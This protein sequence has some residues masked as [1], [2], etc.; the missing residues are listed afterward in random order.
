MKEGVYKLTVKWYEN[1]G[2]ALINLYWTYPGRT[3]T[4]LMS[5]IYA[6]EGAKLMDYAN[7]PTRTIWKVESSFA[8]FL[9]VVDKSNVPVESTEVLLYNVTGNANTLLYTTTTDTNGLA[10]LSVSVYG[11]YMVVVKNE[12]AYPTWSSA[13]IWVSVNFTF[14][15]NE[16][17][18]HSRITKTVTLPL[19]TIDLLVTDLNGYPMCTTSDEITE[20]LLYNSSLA[21]LTGSYIPTNA[22]GYVRFYRIPSGNYTVG[23][24]YTTYIY[25]RVY[26]ED[27]M[28]N[29]SFSALTSGVRV[30]KT[31][32]TDLNVR[33][34]SVDNRSIPSATV[35][36]RRIISGNL[37]I[38]YNITTSDGI[39]TFYRVLNG[40]WTISASYTNAW[41]QSISNNSNSFNIQSDAPNTIK[42][43][44]TDL[45]VYVIDQNTLAPLPNSNV[46]IFEISAPTLTMSL[47]TNSSGYSS[48][49][50][51]LAGSYNISTNYQ[52]NKQTTTADVLSSTVVTVPIVVQYLNNH[53][54]L[55][56][57]SDAFHSVYW[58][59]NITLLVN[60]SYYYN[61]MSPITNPD[62]LNFTVYLGSSVIYTAST[63]DASPMFIIDH[64]NGNYTLMINTTALSMYPASTYYSIVVEAKYS[65][66]TTDPYPSPLLFTINVVPADTRLDVTPST[67]TTNW[68]DT[69]TLTLNYTDAIHSNLPITDANV[70]YFIYDYSHNLLVSNNIT[71]N[72]NIYSVVIPTE[73]YNLVPGDYI[74]EVYIGRKG[75]VNRT[76]SRTLTVVEAPTSLSLVTTVPITVTW[77]ENVSLS[78]KHIN[79]VNLAILNNS[80]VSLSINNTYIYPLTYNATSG[81]YE[82][83]FNSSKLLS[84]TYHV[85]VFTYKQYFLP[86]SVEFTL[87]VNPVPIHF[88]AI[89]VSSA[90]NVTW[91]DVIVLSFYIKTN[92]TDL[93]ITSA[94][95][96]AEWQPTNYHVSGYY[97]TTCNAYFVI[98]NTTQVFEG[99][100]NVTITARLQN[101]T[102]ISMKISVNIN[103]IPTAILSVNSLE[104][105]WG[106]FIYVEINYLDLYHSTGVIDAAV[107]LIFEG[108]YNV[109]NGLG[110]GTYTLSLRSDSVSPGVYNISIIAQR[111][112]YAMSTKV[113]EVVILTPVKIDTN[114]IT[115]YWG[116]QVPVVVNVTNVING[117]LVPN[118]T[119]ILTVANV[120]VQLVDAGNGTYYGLLDLGL[121]KSE[122]VYD[123]NITFYKD[124][125]A[126]TTTTT[127][128]SVKLVPTS[129][130]IV[131]VY[132]DT[133]TIEEGAVRNITIIVAY[134]NTINGKGI[135]GANVTAIALNKTLSSTEIGDG[136]YKLVIDI[137]NLTF[138]PNPYTIRIFAV[139]GNFTESSTVYSFT[140]SESRVLGVP[141]SIFFTG[142]GGSAISIT[143][144][145]VTLYAYKLY[146]IPK[147]IRELD[148]AIKA[149]LKGRSVEFS[150]FPDLNSLL[151]E[152]VAPMFERIGKKVPQKTTTE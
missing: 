125:Y 107:Y 90:Y 29:D 15:V 99:S 140:I 119:V 92:A 150:K 101:Y 121:F 10:I 134:I 42:L 63:L 58:N 16:T 109:M 138:S 94:N 23:F 113:I 35:E 145:G 9:T 131:S 118:G 54:Y 141:R 76:F 5:T 114:K 129:L 3:E 89:N 64:N 52:G 60:F 83:T 32:L 38:H 13:K 7:P 48:F 144:L 70:T 72:T 28:G 40:T 43:N 146:K 62:W 136:Q 137:S 147:I 87:I 66:Q 12:T 55:F 98:L 148:K 20:V 133:E 8:L 30:V 6:F 106:D 47:S 124:L 11:D 103:E 34:A 68:T 151:E 45:Y 135:T 50:F 39:A 67:L 80:I 44:V 77:G 61:G 51:V 18:I 65:N 82:L 74:L 85:T 117:S 36:I 110:N 149:V 69:L 123:V 139:K 56:A 26:N 25:D 84:G 27:I 53:T 78:V 73:A 24:K 93:N 57:L 126:Q 2:T 104:V 100:Y 102:T 71:S 1:A 116:T 19:S 91:S 120:Q 115:G 105:V 130:T 132:P 127:T 81:T 96:L 111:S 37:F 79:L 95:V 33:V 142:I 88:V 14:T 152:D 22:S 17:N 4:L 143:I 59:D 49:Y 97:N 86:A 128:L 75:Y 108:N 21:N 46:T 112:N 31:R 122:T 41:G